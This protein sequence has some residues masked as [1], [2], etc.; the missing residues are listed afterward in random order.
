MEQLY[1]NGSEIHLAD[2]ISYNGQRGKVVFVADRREYSEAYPESDWPLSEHASGFMIEFTNG[3][4]L[5]L[6]SSDEHLELVSR[7]TDR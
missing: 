5:F 2:V 3:A 4:R 6:D 1:Q 7:R